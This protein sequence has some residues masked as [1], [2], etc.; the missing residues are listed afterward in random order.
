MPT[1]RVLVKGK[2]DHPD[3][4]TRVRLLAD[5]GQFQTLAFSEGGSFYFTEALGSF[6]FRCEVEVDA[7]PSA[8]HD[9][10]AEAEFKTLEVL[11]RQ[12]Y[13]FRDIRSSATCM[14]DIKVRRRE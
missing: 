13:P 5:V 4:A 10:I 11:E 1:Y 9:A 3:E 7:G 14:D 2:F 8:E 6:T 12:R